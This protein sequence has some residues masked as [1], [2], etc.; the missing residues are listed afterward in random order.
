MSV[1]IGGTIYACG[2]PS[3]RS[4]SQREPARPVAGEDIAFGIGA[5]PAPWF[6]AEIKHRPGRVSGSA[7]PVPERSAGPG[8]GSMACSLA[9]FH[10]VGDVESVKNGPR[11]EP[12]RARQTRMLPPARIRNQAAALARLHRAVVPPGSA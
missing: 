7:T 4:G 11:E 12:A 10:Q 8:A 5:L 3:L 2:Y 1:V 9:P 6:A